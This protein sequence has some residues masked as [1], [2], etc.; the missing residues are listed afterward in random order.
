MEKGEAMTRPQ[1]AW[2]RRWYRV[3]KRV[4]AAVSSLSP[5]ARGSQQ[6]GGFIP[7]VALIAMVALTALG[8]ATGTSASRD[9][10]AAHNLRRMEMA[11]YAALAGMEH[12]RRNLMLGILPSQGQVTNFDDPSGTN[13]ADFVGQSDAVVMK[14]GDGSYLGTY[15]V[16]A[17]AVKCSGPPAGYSVDK[18]YAQYFDLHAIGV[19]KDATGKTL[20]PASSEVALTV[21]KVGEGRCY[22]R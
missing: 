10:K 9:V 6:E 11:K 7:L 1:K 17:V 12:G 22:K 13:S 14:A 19:L 20:S 3:A 8:V 16:K 15:T 2:H 4:E 21:R 5:P 18:F